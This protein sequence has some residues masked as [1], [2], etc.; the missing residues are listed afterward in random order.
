MKKIFTSLSLFTFLFVS[1]MNLT[2]QS[3]QVSLLEKNISLRG[4][5][6]VDEKTIWVS[7][8]DGSVGKSIDSGNSW[9]WYSVKGFEHAEFRDIQAFNESCAIIISVQEPACILKTLDGGETWKVVY[10]NKTKGMFL[11]AMEFWNLQSG[12][13]IGDP[14]NHYFFIARTF[15]GGNNWKTIP[16]KNIPLADSGEAC[17]ASSGTNIVK[18][19]NKEAVFVTGGK[20]SR[21][22]IR[23]KK[24]DIPIVQGME[25]T[26]ANS[27]A[28]KNATDFIIVGG[29]FNKMEE[30]EKNC[31]ITHNAGK[32]WE[33]PKT[34][35]NG[36]RS[37]VEYLNKQSW[38]C[39]GIN[40]VDLSKDDGKNWFP[41][42]IV[43]FNVCKKAVGGKIIFLAGE[44][45]IAR[46]YLD[47]K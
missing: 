25:T 10:E 34:P 9:K 29:D 17:F 35:P 8:S 32:T 26:G 19:N 43:G 13:V 27:I 46:I 39:C 41:I 14:V 20:R 15:D 37:C 12:I 11:D 33:F 22:F 4:L 7:G 23:D 42:S 2:A 47:K 45:K 44:G 24:I 21:L 28:A 31:V 38:I 3:L 40:G 30:K 5:C 18:I 36:Y 1:T 6:V 16:E